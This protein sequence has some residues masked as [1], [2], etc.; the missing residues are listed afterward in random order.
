MEGNHYLA[1]PFVHVRE[2]RRLDRGYK[3]TPYDPLV[4]GR[5]TVTKQ[6]FVVLQPL[7]RIPEQRV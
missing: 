7:S 4:Q 1:A 5:A 6:Y 2:P 3:R